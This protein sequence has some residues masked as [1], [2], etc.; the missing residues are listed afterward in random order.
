MSAVIEALEFLIQ[1]KT[2]AE[3]KILILTDSS[4]VVF[5]ITKW[6]FG[7][8]KRGWK[9]MENGDVNNRELWERF[10]VARKHFAASAI[11]WKIVPGHSGIPG[12]ERCDQLAVHCQ[13]NQTSHN[14]SYP[15]AEYRFP[16]HQLP[17]FAKFKK[18]DPYYLSLVSGVLQ[19]HKT[20]GECEGRVRGRPGAKFKKVKNL[21]DEEEVLRSWGIG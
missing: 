15:L 19:K 18:I 14:M 2:P 21:N 11:E 7:W 5:G 4:Y 12:N 1:K 3:Q 6:I 10:L 9:T 16:I 13:K 17:D 8:Q 20:W